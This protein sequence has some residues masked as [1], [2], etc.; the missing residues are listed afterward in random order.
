MNKAGE[1]EPNCGDQV[2]QGGEYGLEGVHLVDVAQADEPQGGEH[3]NAD[4]R[5]EVA[6]VNSHCKLEQDGASNPMMLSFARGLGI[7][8]HKASEGRSEERRVGK[9]CRS[10]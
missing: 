8:V 3:E 2:D 9:E 10:R 5:A 6:A 4:T 7:E 1:N